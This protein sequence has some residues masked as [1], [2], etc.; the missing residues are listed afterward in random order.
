MKRKLASVSPWI[1]AA[2]C[3]LLA[4]I[5]GV[6]AVSNYSREK[7]LM[8]DALVQKGLAVVR[9][10][11]T[12]VMVSM[13]ANWQRP[14]EAMYSWVDHVQNVIDQIHN[15]PDIHFV[16]LIDGNGVVLAGTNPERIGKRI[17]SE[18]LHF[19]K[20]TVGAEPAFR[21]YTVNGSSHQAFQVT[22]QYTP[23]IRGP[24]FRSNQHGKSMDMM[25]RGHSGSEQMQTELAKMDRE[26]LS[27]LVELDLDQFNSAVQRKL[28]EIVILSIILLLV[29]VGGWLSLLT[30]QG[31]RGSQT[32]LQQISAFND[33]V[34]ESLPVGL[35]ATDS[36]GNIR[37]VN[38][39]AEKIAGLTAEQMITKHPASVLP[40]EVAELFNSSRHTDSIHINK[41]IVL[42][43]DENSRRSLLLTVLSVADS[44]KSF[45]GD[46][47]LIQDISE[48]RQL[49]TDL[50]RNER[51]AALGKMAAGVA[52]ELR[53]PLSSIK[54]LAVLLKSKT[55]GDAEG[56]RTA[57]VLVQ[58]VER[59]NRSIS[60]LL[61]YTRPEKLQI[62]SVD[63]STVLKQAA[64][65]V[66]VDAESLAIT[67]TTSFVENPILVNVDEDKMKQVF[68]NLLLNSVQ[69]MPDGGVLA[70]STEISSNRLVCTI[71]DSGVGIAETNLSRV[72]DPYF[73]TKSDGTGLGLAL[74]AKIIEEH[75]GTI[76]IDSTEGEGTVVKVALPVV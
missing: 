27:L 15:Q 42:R 51:L 75:G 72:F 44:E 43:T 35:I 17:D 8:T 19:L 40:G 48:L 56:Q 69:A 3:T 38:A 12:G 26:Q 32:R 61:D 70:I 22:R 36:D 55:V 46:V 24:M 20:R 59:L 33:I 4:V 2:A 25:F 11:E 54:G 6:F 76:S 34:V 68:L 64:T 23:R 31:L 57:D 45:I 60:E 21:I 9:Y 1:L 49:E 10:L 65:L 28:L 50:R 5:I 37:M 53:N 47:L 62:E 58:E 73:T 18:S 74:S 30:L 13:R 67:I 7:K 16:E 39:S 41:E 14:G 71:A 63:L 66:G 52:H 29:G